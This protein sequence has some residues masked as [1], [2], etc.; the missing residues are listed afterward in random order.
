MGALPI[1]E[2]CLVCLATS[3][4]LFFFLNFSS[5]YAL[6]SV[7]SICKVVQNWYAVTYLEIGLGRYGLV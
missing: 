5:I 1:A 4:V 2:A 7:G 3:L 6:P